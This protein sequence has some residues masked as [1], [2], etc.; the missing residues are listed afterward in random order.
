M[1]KLVYLLI[2]CLSIWGCSKENGKKTYDFALFFE[3]GDEWHYEKKIYEKYKKYYDQDENLD[4]DFGLKYGRA[5]YLEVGQIFY[6]TDDKKLMGSFLIEKTQTTLF[7]GNQTGS[8][9]GFLTVEGS[10]QKKGRKF[11]VEDGKF[12]FLWTNAE[13]YGMQD[14]VLKGKWT[15]KR[16]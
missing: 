6:K 4:I 14:T 7:S 8:F 5:I 13:A 2:C 3:S 16:L 11:I 15:M 9:E 12:E 10:Y 1:K